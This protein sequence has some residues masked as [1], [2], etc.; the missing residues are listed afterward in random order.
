MAEKSCSFLSMAAPK[1]G[2]MDGMTNLVYICMCIF[3]VQAHGKRFMTMSVRSWLR[4]ELLLRR[5]CD[6]FVCLTHLDLTMFSQVRSK[7][8]NRRINKS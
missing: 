5:G 1:E 3:R 6:S 8:W 7:G 4:L 2:N